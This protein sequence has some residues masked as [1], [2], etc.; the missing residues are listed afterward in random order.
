MSEENSVDQ[1]G[2]KVHYEPHPVSPSRKKELMAEG[3]RIIDERFAPD[4]E[5]RLAKRAKATKKG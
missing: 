2:K 4:Y 3:V 5:Q 1:D